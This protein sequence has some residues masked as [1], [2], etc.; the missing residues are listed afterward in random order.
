MKA[1]LLK[2]LTVSLCLSIG[3]LLPSLTLAKTT[4]SQ[5]WQQAEQA[6]TAKDYQKA[7][8]I[9]QQ[10]SRQQPTA[11][12]YYHLGLSQHRQFKF[13]EA[14]AAYQNSIRLDPKYSQAYINLGLAQL[15]IGQSGEAAKAFQQAIALPD[16]PAEAATTRTIAHYNL[17]IIFNRE[18]KPDQARQQVEQALALTPQFTQAE[19]L[20]KQLDPIQQSR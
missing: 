10:I 9:W 2:R 5:L 17:A 16:Q 8:T 19:E 11:E 18:G 4:N 20:L 12:V 13:L 1:T 3:L 15:E 6:E 7:E 14:I